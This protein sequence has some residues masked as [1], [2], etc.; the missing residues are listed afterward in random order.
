MTEQ[1]RPIRQ[2]TARLGALLL[3]VLL[4]FVPLLL[5]LAESVVLGTNRVERLCQRLGIHDALGQLY[6]P[7]IRLFR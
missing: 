7:V 1:E 4:P 3:I 2:L 6:E 5:A